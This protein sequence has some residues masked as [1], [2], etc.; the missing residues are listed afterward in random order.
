[1]QDDTL[2]GTLAS[3]DIATEENLNDL[4]KVGEA[5]LKKPVSRLNLGTGKLEP[6]HPEVTNEVALERYKFALLFSLSC[7]NSI[8]Y[9]TY[10]FCFVH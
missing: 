7:V 8:N 6:V 9:H 2:S 1:M 3:V 5:L 4:V 10:Y